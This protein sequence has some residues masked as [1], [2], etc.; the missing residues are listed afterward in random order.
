[1][2]AVAWIFLTLPAVLPAT[3]QEVV[4]CLEN[5]KQLSPGTYHS[6]RDTLRELGPHLGATVAFRC[7]NLR[8][9]FVL[10][11]VREEPRLTQPE[12]ALAA[13]RTQNGRVLPRMELYVKPVR[14]ILPSRLEVLEGRALAWAAGHELLH[15]L[16]QTEQHSHGG[17]FAAE[18]NTAMLLMPPSAYPQK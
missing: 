1:M 15:Y 12:N 10:V 11:T 3:G 8:P 4:L 16:L 9:P 18:L 14:R 5:Q 6:F 7:E 2:L 17:Y 13:M